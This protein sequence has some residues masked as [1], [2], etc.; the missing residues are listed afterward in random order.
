MADH[1]RTW[2]IFDGGLKGQI[3]GHHAA[4]AWA[5]AKELRRRGQSVTLYGNVDFKPEGFP[6]PVVPLFR[7]G[8]YQ[9]VSNDQLAGELADFIML[10]NVF[11]EDLSRVDRSRFHRDDVALFPTVSQNQ[12]LAIAQWAQSFADVAPF[13]MVMVTHRQLDHKFGQR[14][15]SLPAM[16]YRYVWT[17]IAPDLA[18]RFF[19]CT[20]TTS[21]A[22]EYA[23]ILGTW[24]TV[25][26]FLFELPTLSEATPH[27][28]EA[29]DFVVA[30]LGS[31]WLT[32]GFGLLPSIVRNT[33]DLPALRYF[34]QAYRMSDPGILRA[35]A[36]LQQE[37]SRVTLATDYLDTQQYDQ[38]LNGAD[39]ILLL[40]DPDSYRARMSGVYVM[41]ALAGKP[42]VAPSGTWM[43][44]QAQAHGSGVL[45]SERSPSGVRRAILEAREKIVTLRERAHAY[46]VELR[47]RSGVGA[48]IDHIE[49]LG[50]AR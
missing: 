12:M 23:Q 3:P 30:H 26:P 48:V 4:E 45:F 29:R 22:E 5:L 10:N 27:A 36:E 6:V 42:V 14:Q 18:A 1:V 20:T 38:A 17:T 35:I 24:P 9:K 34:I 33:V 15:V 2:H 13:K 46:A 28:S 39:L 7:H 11:I 32:K 43:G 8:F 50:A 16:Y 40:H 49:A 47:P 31:P 37:P 19:L 25:L 44:A 21:L 41:A